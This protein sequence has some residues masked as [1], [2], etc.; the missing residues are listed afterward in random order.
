MLQAKSMNTKL[1]TYNNTTIRHIGN[2]YIAL[3]HKEEQKICKFFVVSGGGPALLGMP[4]I[5]NLGILTDIAN[6]VIQ[7]I[8][9]NKRLVFSIK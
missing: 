5:D 2:C 1:K 4:D 9:I 8:T 6:L 7:T 3:T